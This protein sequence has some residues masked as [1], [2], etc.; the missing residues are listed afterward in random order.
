MFLKDFLSLFENEF[1]AFQSSTS[2]I[3]FLKSWNIFSFFG[4]NLAAYSIWVFFWNQTACPKNTFNATIPLYFR[5]YFSIVDLLAKIQV[6]FPSLCSMHYVAGNDRVHLQ[7][8]FE[9]VGSIVFIDLFTKKY[10]GTQIVTRCLCHINFRISF[11]RNP[12]MSS[13]Q[14]IAILDYNKNNVL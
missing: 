4:A 5:V 13:T 2:K 3:E 7:S 6:S 14:W 9:I 1:Y 10:F 12:F 8:K 11:N